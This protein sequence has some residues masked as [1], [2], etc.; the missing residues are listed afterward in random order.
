MIPRKGISSSNLYTLF[1]IAQIGCRIIRC[2]TN[3]MLTVSL[4]TFQNKLLKM[5]FAVFT[6]KNS[7]T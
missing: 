3:M 6:V 5:T 4:K 1:K 2:K 7:I